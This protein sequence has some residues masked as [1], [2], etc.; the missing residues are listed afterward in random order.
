MLTISTRFLAIWIADT[1]IILFSACVCVFIVCAKF[2]ELIW[3]TRAIAWHCLY[4]EV[5]SVAMRVDFLFLVNSKGTQLLCYHIIGNKRR[6]EGDRQTFSESYSSPIFFFS[7]NQTNLMSTHSRFET[8]K[9]LRKLF[10]D[11]HIYQR[12]KKIP[13]SFTELVSGS[14]TLANFRRAILLAQPSPTVSTLD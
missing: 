6:H 9:S 4:V 1:N 2:A 8:L 3:C 13:Q 14:P 11:Y 10:A 12:E 7:F 5:R